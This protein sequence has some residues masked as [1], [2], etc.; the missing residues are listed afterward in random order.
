MRR[1]RIGFPLQ[2]AA[3]AGAAVDVRMPPVL[4]LPSDARMRERKRAGPSRANRLF[5]LPTW[6]Q[7]PETLRVTARCDPSD[8]A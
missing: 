6:V 7:Q 2:L 8:D 1:F 5:P 4:T 3:L